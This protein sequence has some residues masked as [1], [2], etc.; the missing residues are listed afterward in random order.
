MIIAPELIYYIYPN[1]QA[2]QFEIADLA[3]GNGPQIV[4]WNYD[5]PK[6]SEEQLQVAWNAVGDK[7]IWK[8]TRRIRNWKLQESDWTQVKDFQGD[9]QQAWETYRQKLRDV[10]KDFP[11]P[12]DVIWPVPPS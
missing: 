12:Q 2:S 4:Q 1:I 5:E 3:D 8:E 11:T 6:P 7:I 9:N 10:T